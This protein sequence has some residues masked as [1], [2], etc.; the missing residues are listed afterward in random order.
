MT[1][2]NQSLRIF[3]LG[4]GARLLARVTVCLAGLGLVSIAAGSA[5]LSHSSR[6]LAVDVLDH[7]PRGSR[8]ED[9]Q[10]DIVE[11]D[12]DNDGI[13]EI[14]VFYVLQDGDRAYANIRLLK[15]SGSRLSTV[16]EDEAESWGFDN[17][18]GVYPA[19]GKDR[20]HILAYRRIG[21]SCPGVLRIYR[22][23]NRAVQQIRTPWEGTCASYLTLRDLDGDG[24]LEIIFKTLKYGR[25]WDIYRW[26]G[27]QH[28]KSNKSFPDFY[29]EDLAELLRTIR[30]KEPAPGSARISWTEQVVE[31]LILQRRFE[32]GI[33]LCQEVSKMI[34]DPA[35]TTPEEIIKGDETPEMLGRIRERFER[36]KFAAKSRLA[37]LREQLYKLA[38]NS[39]RVGGLRVRRAPHRIA[40]HDG[41]AVIS[42]Q[43][44]QV[45]VRP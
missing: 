4:Q 30:S 26:E 34:D 19:K 23:D 1:P 14:V 29:D 31:I 12:L 10:K 17:P 38:G 11:A 32:E 44:F 9:P 15:R 24:Y 27:E 22:M 8:I 5:F 16:W 35:I 37:N 36:A 43:A 33:Q 42:G 18:T 41:D 3:C 25:N 28:I 2:E 7:L 13:K 20:Y 21:A 39:H 40:A 6:Q 45:E